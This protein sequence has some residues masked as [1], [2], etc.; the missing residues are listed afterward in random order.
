[1]QVLFQGYIQYMFPFLHEPSLFVMYIVR[2][3]RSIWQL[4][5]TNIFEIETIYLG[6]FLKKT[7]F[8]ILLMIL[9]IIISLLSYF[10][11]IITT[12]FIIIIII[13]LHDLCSI[14]RF[15]R[16]IFSWICFLW[17]SSL[18]ETIPHFLIFKA[19]SRFNFFPVS[20]VS[21]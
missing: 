19:W 17:I 6:I 20:M 8:L 1:M 18:F 9:I 15:Q 14:A 16:C 2:V 11:V 7:L 13:Y 12:T 21:L 4:V 3:P 5:R 10:Y